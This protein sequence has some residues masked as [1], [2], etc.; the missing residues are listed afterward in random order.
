M[1][2]TD[3][4]IKILM[5]GGHI[6]PALA[7][8]EE[9]QN[10]FPAWTIV[11]AGR[12]IAL[13]GQDTHSEEYRL[14]TGM[15]I[16]FISITAGR[17][18]REGGL[19]A[20]TAFFKI[21]VGCIQALWHIY[22]EK[23]SVVVSFGGYVGLP[24]VLAAWVTGIPTVTHEQTTRPGLANRMI[25]RVTT[26][27]CVT[28]PDTVSGFPRKADVTVTG[29]PIRKE[30]LH[31]PKKSPFALDTS[32]PLLFIVGGNTGSTSINDVVFRALPQL[33]TTFT[34]VHQVGRISVARADDMKKELDVSVRARYIPVPFVST[35]AYSYLLHHASV[36]A[37]RSGA[38]TVTEVAVSGK[39]ALFIPLPWAAGNEQY[40]NAKI[41]EAAGSAL[42]LEQQ[43]FNESSLVR[44][45]RTLTDELPE[46]TKKA[47]LFAKTIPHDGAARFVRVISD[48]LNG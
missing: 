17:L 15:G 2:T 18:K 46:R 23:P 35:D 43:H 27:L 29:L 36:I 31:P 24:V 25:A 12:K 20:V 28:F 22:R 11:F 40:Y 32:L 34:V 6:T 16:K 4:H 5:T 30:V 44:N 19:A 42:I 1:K 21:P 47:T 7:T 13:E 8:I 26:K 41:L 10:L 33:V 39:V 9:I 37:G 45:I 14:I 3:P 38:N 48:V